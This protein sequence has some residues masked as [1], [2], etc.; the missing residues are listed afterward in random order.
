MIAVMQNLL[1]PV[2]ATGCSASGMMVKQR[3]RATE[4]TSGQRLM[5][6]GGMLG[7][8]A[9]SSCCIVPL[10]LFSLGISGAWIANL[11]GLAPYQ[12]YFIAVTLLFLGGGY[13]LA[14]RASKAA[15][16][17]GAACA[18]PL[19]NRLVKLGLAL[20]TIIVAIA[21]G[22]DLLASLFFNT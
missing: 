15:C 2:V 9:A 16:A 14:Y 19:P 22:F 3:H 21:F 1:D 6:I 17:E 5:A 18:R 8:I 7:A 12:P 11:T 10:L 4:S 20:A 13:W